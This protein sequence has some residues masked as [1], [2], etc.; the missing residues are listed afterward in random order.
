MV[1]SKHSIVNA[2]VL[3]LESSIEHDL[4]SVTCVVLIGKLSAPPTV[5]CNEYD[6][7]ERS[8]PPHACMAPVDSHRDIA[9]ANPDDA[10]C[11]F[12][13]SSLGQAG[14]IKADLG[15]SKIRGWRS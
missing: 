9:C 8:C 12:L 13:C 14:D 6:I 2:V 3:P 15:K 11:A 7:A 10:S 1:I 4:W 5:S